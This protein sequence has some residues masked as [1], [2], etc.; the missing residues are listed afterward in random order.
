MA[1]AHI[2]AAQELELLRQ[3]KGLVSSENPEKTRKRAIAKLIE[4]HSPFIVSIVRGYLLPPGV[5]YEDA[6]A[7]AK[8]GFID[9]ID[10]FDVEK[11]YRLNTYAIYRVKKAIED[12]L[13]QMGFATKIPFTEV[14]K[15]R[16]LLTRTEVNIGTAS[17]EDLITILTDADMKF[18]PDADIEAL[19]KKAYHAIHGH[20]NTAIA[21]LIKGTMSVM[22][23]DDTSSDQE[24]SRAHY[25]EMQ[26]ARQDV[27]IDVME[28]LT[29]EEINQAIA[30]LPTIE[31]LPI[32]YA[33]GML[34]AD[35]P[36]RVKKS[37]LLIGA[38][39]N[40]LEHCYRNAVDQ[41]REALR[42]LKES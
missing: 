14:V 37:A 34:D 23:P 32:M 7:E 12:F 18:A 1:E 11:G 39:Y 41:V 27:A 4:A 36:L 2:T 15:T 28:D 26:M 8:A 24:A 21:S 16:R 40:L 17:R 19:R 33:F 35:N 5:E 29:I 10:R 20:K 6:I 22:A 25:V 42:S 38:P 3:A 9:A 13:T 30:S 31:A